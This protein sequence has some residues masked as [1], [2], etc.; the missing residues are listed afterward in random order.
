MSTRIEFEGMINVRI[1]TSKKYGKEYKSQHF[2]IT[3][4]LD[5]V[6]KYGL[7]PNQKVKVIILL[8]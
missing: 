4:P 5:L 7:R 6:Y 3:I 1:L 2:Y 8:D